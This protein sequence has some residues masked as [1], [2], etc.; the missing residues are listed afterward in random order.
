MDLLSENIEIC[1]ATPDA[2]VIEQ[3][4][5]YNGYMYF[6]YKGRFVVQ[7]SEFGSQE[8]GEVESLRYLNKGDYFGEVS[9][10]FGCNRSAT[11]KTS[12]YGMYGR[13][14]DSIL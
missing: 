12:D 14:Q 11:V 9:L 5:P 10:L 8:Q 6:V 3:N 4:E 7:C 13:L 1:Y 2:K